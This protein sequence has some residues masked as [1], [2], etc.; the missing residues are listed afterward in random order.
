MKRWPYQEI[1]F[2]EGVT[3][4]VKYLL[5]A[6]AVAFVVQLFLDR[7][8]NGLFTQ[9]YAGLSLEGIRH[10]RV[11]QLATYMFLHG[12]LLHFVLNMLVL[13]FM[14][15]ET[16]RALGTRHFV[17][18]YFLSGI[19]GGLGWLLISSASWIP[20]IGASGAVF[21]VIGAFAALFPN[22]MIT[23]LVFFILPI[24]LRAWVLAVGLAA[25]ELVYLFNADGGIA[26]AA[27]LAGGLSG[28]VYGW[29][30]SHGMSESLRG[31][32]S[33]WTRPTLTVL[34]GGQDGVMP[35]K[36]E[37]DAILDKISRHG[38]HSLSSQERKLLEKASHNL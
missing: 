1:A 16:E 12:G 32:T 15:P 20:C 9:L 30:L 10:G 33:S 22:R 18:L 17:L 23:V 8:T 3:P 26:Y 5:I 11:W 25:M 19:L 34:K 7:F 28:Y 4:G 13:F 31:V 24:T 27:H 29:T 38:I 2:R 6:T 37:I 36:E 35:S 21:G 14:G